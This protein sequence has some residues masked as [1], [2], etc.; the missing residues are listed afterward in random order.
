[1]SHPLI[2]GLVASLVVLAQAG[3]P[4]M[5][6]VTHWVYANGYAKNHPNMGLVADEYIR[7]IDV[8][9]NGRLKIR[10]VAAGALLKPENMIDGVRAGVAQMGSAVS[11]FFPGQLPISA[12]LGGI[13]DLR[14][15][16]SLDPAGVTAVTMKLLSETPEFAQEYEKLGLKAVFWISP[17]PYAII[18]NKEIAR[19][20]DLQGK[21]LRSFGS[22]LPQL[23]TSVGAVPVSMAYGEVYTSLQTGVIDG[24]LSDVNGMTAGKWEEVAKHVLTTGP[25]DGA[26]NAIAPLVYIVN[27]QAWNALPSDV[28][29]AVEKVSRELG[30]DA[31]K[32]VSQSAKDSVATIEKAGGSVRHLSAA[33]TEAFAAKAPNFYQSAAKS[34]TD[35]GLPGQRIVDKYLET[36]NGYLSG[37]WKP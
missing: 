5:A 15:G 12:T 7:R 34:L 26:L 16:N 24:A 28:R 8:A 4:A 23:F 31:A 32:I 33:D 21:K 1:M 11:F 29:Q 6:Q 35:L 10:H 25:K 13:T 2:S 20:S 9:T 36:V 3:T 19:L 27:L 37:A 30:P 17:P 14:I 22:S 18:A